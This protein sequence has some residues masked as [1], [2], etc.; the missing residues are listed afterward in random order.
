MNKEIPKRKQKASEKGE[1]NYALLAL[2]AGI[3]LL[4][5]VIIVEVA[6]S[7]YNEGYYDGIIF[8]CNIEDVTIVD[9]RI[10]AERIWIND[11]ER[12]I[13]GWHQDRVLVWATPYD[14]ITVELV[15]GKMLTEIVP[16][17]GVYEVG[18]VLCSAYSK[19][20]CNYVFGGN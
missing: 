12:G 2:T 5:I 1:P 10:Q 4:A 18:S 19:E 17:V 15:N 3:I 20:V 8:D 9:G 7:A 16:C 11:K 6:Q 14:E 13:R